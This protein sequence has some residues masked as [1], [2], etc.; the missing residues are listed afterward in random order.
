VS[1]SLGGSEAIT[2]LKARWPT[3]PI[4]VLT[5]INDENMAL[6]VLAWGLKIVW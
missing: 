1:D 6:S 3:V 2:V 4:V 5:D